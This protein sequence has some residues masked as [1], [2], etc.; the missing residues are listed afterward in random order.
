MGSLP[1]SQGLGD[2]ELRSGRSGSR[3]LTGYM[4][5]WIEGLWEGWKERD[6]TGHNLK[7]FNVILLATLTF[8]F[9]VT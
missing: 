6:G 5:G 4:S 3:R 7:D 8:S 9:H 2:K 1:D